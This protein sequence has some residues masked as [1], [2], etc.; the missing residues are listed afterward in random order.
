MYTFANVRRRT[1]VRRLCRL[2]GGLGQRPD[3]GRLKKNIPAEC[4]CPAGEYWIWC[5]RAPAALC[6]GSAFIYIWPFGQIG[7]ILTKIGKIMFIY[8]AV[9][10]I[11]NIYR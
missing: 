2:A 1:I 5:E 7:K 4:C 8:I 10:I 11:Y 6:Y 3:T 9:T